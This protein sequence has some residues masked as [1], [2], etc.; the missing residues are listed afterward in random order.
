MAGGVTIKFAIVVYPSEEGAGARFTA[1]CLNMDLVAEH[2]C[3]E[4]AVSDLLESIEAAIEA[5]AKYN[6]NPFRD[7][8]KEYWDKLARAQ[9]IPSELKERIIF[10]ANRRRKR[11]TKPHINVETQC[12]LRQLQLV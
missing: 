2:D 8:P 12:D 3:V 10:N 11:L 9:P 7:A 5:G 1:H 4:G 6:A